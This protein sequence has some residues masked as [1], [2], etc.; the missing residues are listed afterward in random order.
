MGAWTSHLFSRAEEAKELGL[1]T[2]G[3]ELVISSA[4][5]FFPEDIEPKLLD[6]ISPNC[7]LRELRGIDNSSGWVKRDDLFDNAAKWI[8]G[9]YSTFERAE[10]LCEAGYSKPGDKIL[11]NRQHIIM[12]DAAFL[13][14]ILLEARTE[15]IAKTLRW[16]RSRRL[17]GVVVLMSNGHATQ[18]SNLDRLAFLCDAFDGDSILLAE[19]YAGR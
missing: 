5:G 16:A 11:E 4:I 8:L 19:L 2:K 3:D 18:D 6:A 13:Y 15:T 10:L 7:S 14:Q 12:G 17:L 9:K 1:L